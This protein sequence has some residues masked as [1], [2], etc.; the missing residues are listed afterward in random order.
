MCSRA[1]YLFVTYLDAL[2]AYHFAA[3]AFAVVED[4]VKSSALATALIARREYWNHVRLHGC[5]EAG[6]GAGVDE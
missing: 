2:D 1:N 4:A 6:V 5:R 3:R